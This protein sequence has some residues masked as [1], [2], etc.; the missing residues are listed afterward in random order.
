MTVDFETVQRPAA[1]FAEALLG[2][3]VR[4]EVS[5]DQPASGRRRLAND[6]GELVVVLPPS[7]DAFD[8]RQ[9]DRRIFRHA[10]LHQAAY[11][12]FGTRDFDVDDFLARHADRPA[13]EETF[14]AIEEHRVDAVVRHRF[15][16]AVDDVHRAASL[17]PPVAPE[18]ATVMAAIERRDDLHRWTVDDAAALALVLC[19][20]GGLS[21]TALDVAELGPPSSPEH[22]PP[23]GGS[24]A[25]DADGTLV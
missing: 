25:E 24:G 12:L 4:L 11:E 6:D 8:D 20:I 7:V 16:G 19:P 17:V 22:P 3:P 10:V 21:P 15:P 13:L 2:R 1:M 14:T 23:V 9:L 5:D 18:L